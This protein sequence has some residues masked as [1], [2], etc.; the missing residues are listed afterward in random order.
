MV[1]QTYCYCS[2]S[3]VKTF[4]GQKVQWKQFA[5]LSIWNKAWFST[6]ALSPWWLY[7]WWR[8]LLPPSLR[9]LRCQWGKL[10][11]SEFLCTR[12]DGMWMLWC[13]EAI[14]SSSLS[15]S[16]CGCWW[17]SA[18]CSFMQIPRWI[19]SWRCLRWKLNAPKRY[20]CRY[21]S[22][23]LFWEHE[24][25]R[26]FWCCDSHAILDLFFIS[27][28]IKADERGAWDLVQFWLLTAFS[29]ALDLWF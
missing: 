18:S 23:M 20:F 1:T 15:L 5:S 2:L 6:S 25:T 10:V 12:G 29:T 9:S 24:K 14:G 27:F 19:E 7:L 4:P 13:F 3:P 22:S 16:E 17:G 28:K 21:L 26:I 8:C 11:E